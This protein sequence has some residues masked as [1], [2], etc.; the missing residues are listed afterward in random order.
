MRYI[1]DKNAPKKVEIRA[2]LACFVP[3]AHTPFQWQPQNSIEEF[4]QKKKHLL[5]RRRKRITIKI[6][7][8]KTSYLEGL[9][10]RGDRRLAEVILS[11][12]QRGCKFDGWSEY[13]QFDQ[14]I[15]ALQDCNLDPDFYTTRLRSYEEKFPWDFID[16]GVKK[17]YLQ[18]E[19][20]KAKKEI[21]TPDCR[22]NACVGCGVS[23]CFD[24]EVDREV[25]KSCF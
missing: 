6:H 18:K 17:S 25:E 7:D 14:W 22:Q 19:N 2:S 10:A 4:E 11:A 12:W 5:S 1:G 21:I 13:F 3:K 23:D 16:T 9:L 8:S 15:K 20:E 24:I